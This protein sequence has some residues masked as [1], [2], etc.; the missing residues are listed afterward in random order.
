MR[1]SIAMTW[2]TGC[3]YC[4]TWISGVSASEATWSGGTWSIIVTSP[5]RSAVTA[6]SPWDSRISRTRRI[7]GVGVSDAGR[8]S[9]DRSSRSRSSRPSGLDWKQRYRPSVTR[10]RSVAEVAIRPSMPGV[11]RAD[12]PEQPAAGLQGRVVEPQLDAVLVADLDAIEQ[13]GPARLVGRRVRVAA[14]DQGL[15]DVG[16]RRPAAS[17]RTR[18]GRAGGGSRSDGPGRTS[19]RTP[20]AAPAACPAAPPGR[21][22]A[23]TGR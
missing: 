5:R 18:S 20:R 12:R 17:R 9:A 2:T 21:P 23:R 7:F 19:R 8:R 11:R 3:A 4:P 15:G 1:P 22:C 16:R 10:T 6:A 13:V 14:L